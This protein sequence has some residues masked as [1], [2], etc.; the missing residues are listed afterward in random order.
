MTAL[1]L[2]KG[3]EE[4]HDTGW[5]AV[6]AV[7]ILHPH[8]VVIKWWCHVEGWRWRVFSEENKEFCS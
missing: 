4:G 6:A 1:L 7:E 2:A 8:Y 5:E 3:L